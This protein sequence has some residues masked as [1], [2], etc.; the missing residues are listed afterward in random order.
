MRKVFLLS[1]LFVSF[2]YVNQASAQITINLP[3]FPKVKKNKP[4]EPKQQPTTTENTTN[5]QPQ[6]QPVIQQPNT[7]I[8]KPEPQ[9]EDEPMDGRLGLFL[10][11]IGKAQKEVERY[12]ANDYMYLVGGTSAEWLMRAVSPKDRSEWTEKWKVLMTPSVQ[13]RFD[14]AFQ[15]LSASAALKLPSYNSSLNK[16]SVHNP[17][18]EKMMKGV[19]TRIADY[20]IYSVGL[21]E[22]TWLIDKNDY[23][24]PTARYKHG[25]I[26]LRDTKSDHPYCYASYINIKQDYA[27]GGTYGASY[28]RFIE[29]E[30][31]GCPA[32][33]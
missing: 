18:E 17:V 32:G 12:N 16:Y 2:V 1:A 21:Q 27:G 11:E 10:D 31:V 22:R 30:L 9:R 15:N 20:K 3:K 28:A 7:V 4:E 5:T 26:W 24:L 6:S 25:V 33:K 23:G 14:E 8:P 13:K 19:L 29:D